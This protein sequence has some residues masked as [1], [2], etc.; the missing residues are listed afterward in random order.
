MYP[1]DV[2]YTS[3]RGLQ[4]VLRP[5]RRL[6]LTKLPPLPTPNLLNTTTKLTRPKQE[7]RKYCKE[8]EATVDSYKAAN[9]RINANCK[10]MAETLLIIITKKKVYMEGEFEEAQ[11][12]HREQVK[13]QFVRCYQEIKQTMAQTFLTFANDSDEVSE[14]R[15]DSVGVTE[16]GSTYIGRTV[17]HEWVKYTK[18]IDRKVEDALRATV[19]KSLQDYTVSS[20][21]IGPLPP[22][23]QELSRLLNG[24]KKTEVIPIFNVMVFLEK[25]NRVELRPSVQ[26]IFNMIHN[27]SR[28]LITVVS[29]VPR[30][31]ET[32]EDAGTGGAKSGNL[33]TFYESISN[34]EDATLKTIVSITTG[35]SSIVEK[36]Q[37]FLSYWEK[38]YKHIWDQDKDAYIRR[39]DKAKKPLSAFD[40]DITKYKELQD[41]VVAEE[42]TN[43]M[44]FLKQLPIDK[45][46]WSRSDRSYSLLASL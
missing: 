1:L 7:A 26:D 2:L 11:K 43:H 41:E 28:E 30:L 34:D 37:S 17:R 3:I 9:E 8:V 10:I 29:H 12:A 40:G 13:G 6:H 16:V 22:P 39:Y 20:Y 32:A 24:D 19:K 45:C 21:L 38:K 18:K 31:V 36:V 5:C 25:N 33:P 42:T 23:P 27:V 14:E 44:R 35:V 15:T 4:S 46:V